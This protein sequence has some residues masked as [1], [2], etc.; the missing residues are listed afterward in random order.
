MP[1]SYSCQIPHYH[2]G[3][4]FNS[5]Y[6]EQSYYIPFCDSRMWVGVTCRGIHML[7]NQPHN[8]TKPNPTLPGLI[9][10]LRCV[11][12]AFGQSHKLSDKRT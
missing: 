4:C 2:I 8:Q 9:S 3:A 10:F 12:Y 6:S 7:S 11:A 1:P 5:R